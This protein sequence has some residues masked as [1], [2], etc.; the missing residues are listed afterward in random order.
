[1]FQPRAHAELGG[2]E[3]RVVP[4]QAWARYGMYRASRVCLDTDAWG[5][6]AYVQRAAESYP[7]RHM[8]FRP[9]GPKIGL[10]T[11]GTFPSEEVSQQPGEPIPG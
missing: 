2:S 7:T 5:G 9:A 6:G 11:A 4:G 3:G 8:Q 10:S 1:M